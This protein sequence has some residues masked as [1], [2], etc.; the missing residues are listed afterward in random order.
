MSRV[1]LEFAASTVSRLERSTGALTAGW[2]AAQQRLQPVVDVGR[3]PAQGHE[4]DAR[5]SGQRSHERR[6]W[7]VQRSIRMPRCGCTFLIDCCL[8][9]R[10]AQIDP[11]VTLAALISLPRS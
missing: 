10:R 4:A 8:E 2:M 3:V 6:L 5:L 7:E 1:L 9:A 11:E